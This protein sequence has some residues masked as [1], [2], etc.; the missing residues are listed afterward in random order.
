MAVFIAKGWRKIGIALALAGLLCACAN[1]N[2]YYDPLKAHHRPDGFVNPQG[3]IGV[4]NIPW[5]EVLFRRL[6][7]DFKPA[8]EPAGGYAQFIRD[9]TLPVDLPLIHQRHDAPVI[10][11]LGH[12]GQLLQVGGK[13]ILI[14]PHL[15]DHAGPFSWLSSDRR[16]P[17]PLKVEELPSI[18]FVRRIAVWLAHVSVSRSA[19]GSP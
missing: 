16:V 18:D 12:A 13:N 2:P 1:T 15:G 9:W 14:D 3:T 19:I 6:R 11:W 17:P 5:Y 10:T 7:G 4:V 8:S